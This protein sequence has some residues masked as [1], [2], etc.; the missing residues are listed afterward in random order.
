MKSY[1]KISEISKLYNI[2]VDSLR[3]YEEIELIQPKRGTNNYRYYSME[4]IYRLNVIKDLRNLGFSIPT[5]KDYL[6]HRNIKKTHELLSHEV[7]TIDEQIAHLN[8]MKQ[9]LKQRIHAITKI[10]DIVFNTVLEEKLM[11]QKCV[12]LSCE[13]SDP[14]QFDFLL[15][16]LS[17]EYEKNLFIIGNFH[18]G[19]ILDY[20]KGY[21]IQYPSV[22][23]S[24]NTLERYE[25]LL[26]AG[27]YLCVY[28]HGK[29]DLAP[30]LD[31]LYQYMEEH[32]YIA[33][34]KPYLFYLI[35]THETLNP[36]EYISKIQIQFTSTL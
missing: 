2:G 21:P 12:T 7:A 34:S 11:E 4:D 14:Q 6:A 35:D 22:F 30:Y 5:I 17:K 27:S 29:Q 8:Q 26:P 24:G 3:Y 15:T 33:Q 20:K 31:L 13:S 16:R 19:C 28:I 32:R 36:K 10:K 25:F 9:H 23:L 1:Y 18:T